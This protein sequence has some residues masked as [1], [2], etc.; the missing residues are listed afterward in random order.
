MHANKQMS[1]EQ[2]MAKAMAQYG[3]DERSWP[4]VDARTVV[5][6]RVERER[7]DAQRGAS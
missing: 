1:V 4:M 2:A 3:L 5:M 6:L 7:R